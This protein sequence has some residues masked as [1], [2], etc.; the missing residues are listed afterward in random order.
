MLRGD[1]S[2][3]DRRAEPP[4]NPPPLRCRA[5]YLFHRRCLVDPQGSG[6]SFPRGRP[7][8]GVCERRVRPVV[9]VVGPSQPLLLSSYSRRHHGT[10]LIRIGRATP[11]AGLNH[12]AAPRGSDARCITSEPRSADRRTLSRP[13]SQGA[14]SDSRGTRLGPPGNSQ[15]PIPQASLRD[16]SWSDREV[17]FIVR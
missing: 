4:T 15:L 13:S 11:D 2:P 7:M 5:R 16:Q 3:A 17:S 10:I 9:R 1:E 8:L 6:T 12:V 14:F